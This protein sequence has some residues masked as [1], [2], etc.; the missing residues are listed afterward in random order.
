[1]SRL[2]HD[3][4]VHFGAFGAAGLFVAQRAHASSSPSAKTPLLS[5]FDGRCHTAIG[6]SSLKLDFWGQAPHLHQAMLFPHTARRT[7]AQSNYNLPIRNLSLL[8]MA[9]QLSRFRSKLLAAGCQT[10]FPLAVRPANQDMNNAVSLNLNV[11]RHVRSWRR[12][13]VWHSF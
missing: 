6:V 3:R 4:S 9:G 11:N 2:P 7:H 13:T 8:A 10:P 5:C 1:M 12:A